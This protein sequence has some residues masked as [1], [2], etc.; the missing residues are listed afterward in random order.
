MPRCKNIPKGCAASY[1]IGTEK[2]PLGCGY[3]PAYE[4]IGTQMTG[5]DGRP[6]MVGYAGVKTKRWVHMH[7]VDDYKSRNR[8][9]R[10]IPEKKWWSR[11]FLS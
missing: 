9:C 2:S 11:F 4:K 5:K 8:K 6:Y 10:R 1:Y 3:C 7:W